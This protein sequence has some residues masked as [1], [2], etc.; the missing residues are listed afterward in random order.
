MSLMSDRRNVG[1]PRGRRQADGSAEDPEEDALARRRDAS[2]D[3]QPA[4]RGL[5]P[6]LTQPRGLTR[7]FAGRPAGQLRGHG[8]LAGAVPALLL[9]AGSPGGSL[10]P[11]Q[12]VSAGRAA[13]AGPPPSGLAGLGGRRGLGYS[14]V[15]IL[16]LV[17]V[18]SGLEL[19]AERG[20]A[21]RRCLRGLVCPQGYPLVVCR[22]FLGLP[23]GASRP[24]LLLART[25]VPLGRLGQP[26][27]L[28]LNRL[29]LRGHAD[30]PG[31]LV[32]VRF[33]RPGLGGLGGPRRGQRG[34]R[35]VDRSVA[36]V[37]IEQRGELLG[38]PG[39]DA[40][41]HARLAPRLLQRVPH[42]TRDRRWWIYPQTMQAAPAVPGPLQLRRSLL[43]THDQIR[44]THRDPSP[45]KRRHAPP[46]GGPPGVRTSPQGTRAACGVRLMVCDACPPPP[47][48][49]RRWHGDQYGGTGVR[50]GVITKSLGLI[51]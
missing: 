44:I 20:R 5:P 1:K 41:Y 26:F 22:G 50:G 46:V 9:G 33:G 40:E 17:R 11:R 28:G 2:R 29:S 35:G 21:W 32:P 4:L 39:I 23:P 12:R 16:V 27:A 48:P 51:T 24:R 43:R 42:I 7:Q 37:A 14:R 13:R 38:L 19:R 31:T 45:S 49:I 3:G 25:V 6:G 10:L 15:G 36:V 18:V 47:S 30:A 8:F 34:D